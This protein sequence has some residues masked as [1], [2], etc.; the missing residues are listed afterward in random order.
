MSDEVKCLYVVCQADPLEHELHWN[1][2]WYSG[3]SEDFYKLEIDHNDDG[4]LLYTMEFP[5]D[6]ETIYS[7]QL[8]MLPKIRA[9]LTARIE[10]LRRLRKKTYQ[11]ESGVGNCN[12]FMD[13]LA[14]KLKNGDIE[15]DICDK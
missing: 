11:E 5:K 7:A 10:N 1:S 14:E 13:I 3:Y 15:G 4:T 8:K 2:C 6:E 12:K 9:D